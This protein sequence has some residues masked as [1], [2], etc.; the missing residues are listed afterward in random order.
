MSAQDDAD[1]AEAALAATVTGPKSVEGDAGKVEAQPIP[2]L[3]AAKKYLD[4]Q[5]AGR[6]K[7]LGLRLRQGK[8][9]S[10]TGRNCAD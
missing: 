6:T 4:A 7:S 1:A 10:A 3:I 2:D 9:P 5:V 8:L